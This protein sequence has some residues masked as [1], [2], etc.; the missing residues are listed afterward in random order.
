MQ[1]TRPNLCPGNDTASD[2][3]IILLGRVPRAGEK[4]PNNVS[5]SFY[6][7]KAL[8]LFLSISYAHTSIH[9]SHSFPP[10]RRRVVASQGNVLRSFHM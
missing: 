8:I 2:F 9:G 10:L 5:C 1:T 3:E 7:P 6:P 4:R